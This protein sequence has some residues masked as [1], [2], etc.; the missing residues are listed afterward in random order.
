M[1]MDTYS[2]KQYIEQFHLLFLDHLSRKLDS[3]FY[4]LKGGC[5]LRF[6]FNSIRYSEDIDLDVQ[7]IQKETLQ[8]KIQGIFTSLPFT[9]ILRAKGIEIVN[10]SPTKQ[11]ETTQRWKLLIKA[12]GIEIPLPTKIEFSRRGLHDDIK[13]ETINFH[14]LQMYQLMPVMI[15]HYSANTALKQKVHALAARNQTQ[16]RDVFDLYLL[17]TSQTPNIAL[18][19][20]LISIIDEAL[21]KIFTITFQDFKG[22]VVAYLTPEY[23]NQYNSAKIWSD[24]VMKVVDF[25]ETKKHA[26]T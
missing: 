17:L 18:E 22:Q 16:A 26:I 5:N 10:V 3:K 21:D 7:I 2:T 13:F 9:Q 15:N 6:F 19:A 4:A 25:L 14:I 8:K 20:E 23:Q 12:D 1:Q 24:M 11:T